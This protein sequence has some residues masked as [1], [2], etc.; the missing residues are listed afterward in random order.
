MSWECWIWGIL[1]IWFF[2][3]SYIGSCT[4]FKDIEMVSVYLVFVQN[5]DSLI[6]ALEFKG[7]VH[8]NGFHLIQKFDGIF[9]FGRRRRQL[10]T[11]ICLL[12]FYSLTPFFQQGKKL[13]ILYKYSAIGHSV[14]L[15]TKTCTVEN[16]QNFTLII[17]STKIMWNWISQNNLT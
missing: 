7:F 16:F 15:A 17:F 3:K 9:L 6:L 11:V 4:F 2:K 1:E 12:Q 14:H 5:L 10:S 8:L 13:K